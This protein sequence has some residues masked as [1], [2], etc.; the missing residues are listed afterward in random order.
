V[1]EEPNKRRRFGWSRQVANDDDDL[2]S[3]IAHKMAKSLEAARDCDRA[4][5]VVFG[6]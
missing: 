3:P 6:G 5:L 1:F 4:M 2:S